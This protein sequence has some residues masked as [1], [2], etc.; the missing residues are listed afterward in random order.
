M[1]GPAQ[2]W[3]LARRWFDDRLEFDWRRRTV[4]ERQSILN[5]VGLTGE[6]W[7]LSAEREDL[8]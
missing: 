4:T 2:L 8:D 3:E 5:G 1:F 7:D 6:F